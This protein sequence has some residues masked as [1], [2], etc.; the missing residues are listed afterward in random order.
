MAWRLSS[1]AQAGPSSHDEV[2]R[3][4]VVRGSPPSRRWE[5]APEE[6]LGLGQA[7]LVPVQAAFST[8]HTLIPHKDSFHGP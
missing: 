8:N 1:Q 2:L 7:D 5:A 6:R 3:R 4:P